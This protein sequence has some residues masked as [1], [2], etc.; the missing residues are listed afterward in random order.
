M[1]HHFNTDLAREY[2][3]EEAIL[4]HN[5]Y[6]WIHKNACNDKHFHDG[7]Y[8][9]YNTTKAFASLFPYMNE[10]KIFRSLKRLEECGF[11]IKGNFNVAKMDRTCW[12]AFTDSA[13]EYLIGLGF[14]DLHFGKMK[15]GNCQNEMTIPDNNITNKNTSKKEIEIEESISTKKEENEFVEK[16]YSLYPTKC[17]KRN[18]SLGKQ[19]KDKERIRK[20]L[21]IYT[22][23]Q[24]ERVIRFEIGEKYGKHYMSNFSTFLNNFPDP[25]CIEKSLSSPTLEDH[26]N[27]GAVNEKGEVW[28][29]QL[30]KWLK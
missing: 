13:I 15:N 14:D 1:E 12:Y 26:P 9:T 3:I 24:V 27:D 7:R 4:I 21:K 19:A 30:Q 8:W 10:T 18:S 23:E 16:M 25:S 17:P 22:M 29:A 2:G 6:Y 11:I 28:S 20:L 5:L